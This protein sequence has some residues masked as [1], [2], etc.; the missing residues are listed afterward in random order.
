MGFLDV[1]CGARQSEL[2]IKDPEKI[3]FDPR[4]IVSQLATIIAHIWQY[5]NMNDLLEN[6]FTISLVN[7]PDYNYSV[8][9]KVLSILERHQ[10]TN[11]HIITSYKSF[12]EQVNYNDY[13]CYY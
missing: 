9:S 8:V 12:I 1:L 5:E 7:H 11:G 4:K 3:Q 2:K 13:F 6:G 10:L